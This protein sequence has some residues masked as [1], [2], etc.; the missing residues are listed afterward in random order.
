MLV[1]IKT[2]GFWCA[3]FS[4]PLPKV[5]DEVARRSRDGE[6]AVERRQ[7]STFNI[8]ICSAFFN[9]AAQSY[10]PLTV[11]GSARATSSPA[12][13]RGEEKKAPLTT[14]KDFFISL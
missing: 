12:C 7:R 14:H 2:G 1:L 13:G 11:T 5:G 4:S 6:G 10:R 3:L 8:Q 9:F